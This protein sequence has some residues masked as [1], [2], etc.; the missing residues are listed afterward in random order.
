MVNIPE[1][2]LVVI[3]RAVIGEESKQHSTSIWEMLSKASIRTNTGSSTDHSIF[4][5]LN[6]M[7]PLSEGTYKWN[8]SN[9]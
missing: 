3:K 6:D 7:S 4:T 5:F 8:G 2:E 1:R 9:G